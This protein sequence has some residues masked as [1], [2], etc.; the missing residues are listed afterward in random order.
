MNLKIDHYVFTICIYDP[1]QTKQTANETLKFIYLCRLI[2][3]DWICGFHT[4]WLNIGFIY[5]SQNVKTIQNEHAVIS[6]YFNIKE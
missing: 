1:D 3:D 2:V 4:F 5:T 6:E